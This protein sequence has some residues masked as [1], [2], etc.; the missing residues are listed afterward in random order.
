MYNPATNLI[1]LQGSLAGKRVQKVTGIRA[2]KRRSRLYKAIGAMAFLTML[3]GFAFSL[4]FGANIERNL[5]QLAEVRQAAD[6]SRK[7][8]QE[9][10]EQKVK[11]FSRQHVQA[12][13]AVKLNLY[14]TEKKEDVEKGVTI[15]L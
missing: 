5:K 1:N 10:R 3:G 4:W 11:L 12:A 8:N 13:A 15:R 7:H 9:L 2:G 14:P 6:Q